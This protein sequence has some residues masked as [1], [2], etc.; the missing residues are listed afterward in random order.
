MR[1]R[2]LKRMLQISQ[3]LAPQGETN[4]QLVP[5]KQTKRRGDHTKM[6]RKFS[7]KLGVMMMPPPVG[8]CQRRPVLDVGLGYA[9]LRD[10]RIH[11]GLKVHAM[12]SGTGIAIILVLME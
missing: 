12:L 2:N 11:S 3:S 8:A 4:G 6:M 5:S 1:A 9:L 10:R 7:H